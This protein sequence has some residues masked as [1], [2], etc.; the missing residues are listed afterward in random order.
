MKCLDVGQIYL[1]LEHELSA[2]EAAVVEHHCAD[3]SR[4]QAALAERRALVAA[5]ESLPQL[6]P[7][8]N[9]SQKVMARIFT[10]T[11]S[12][13]NSLLALSAGL[14]AV[15]AV[16]FIV[17][18][19]SGQNL[20]NFLIGINR[21]TV[22]FAKDVIVVGAKAIKLLT[23]LGKAFTQILEFIFKGLSRFTNILSL[24]MQIIMVSFT[25]VFS[26]IF[27]IRLRKKFLIGE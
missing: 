1:Y 18:L 6:E 2:D 22:N 9:F 27:Y 11:V 10:E 15:V 14:S 17:F 5:A 24:E 12:L 3:C 25:L 20:V 8:P 7:P 4:C 23:I 13:R 19:Q 16:L 21:S 26:L